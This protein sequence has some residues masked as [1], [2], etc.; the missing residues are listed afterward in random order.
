MSIRV[1][2]SKVK[3]I[4]LHEHGVNVGA[5]GKYESDQNAITIATQN[6]EREKVTF[7]HEN[8]H[9]IFDFAGIEDMLPDGKEEAFEENFIHRVS[10]VL[11]SW[12][13]ENRGVVAFLQERS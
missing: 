4:E 1:D 6:P 8:L 11:L 12:L 10:P 5:L 3:D 2:V 7:L 9:L 13:R